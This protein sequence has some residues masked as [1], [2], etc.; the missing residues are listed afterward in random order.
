MVLFDLGDL[1][2]T[3]GD[4]GF[5]FKDGNQHN[6]LL[7]LN[8][9]FRNR[10]G[11][12]FEGAFF[13]GDGLADFEVDRNL[14]CDFFGGFALEWCTSFFGFLGCFLQQGRGQHVEDFLLA[15]WNRV[16]RITDETSDTRCVPD[17]SPSVFG[18]FHADQ[19]VARNT[20]AVDYL[21][22]GVLKLDDF[23]HRNLDFVNVVFDFESLHTSLEVCFDPTFVP[24]VGVDD[25]P[26]TG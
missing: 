12:R 11:Q 13:D 6:E 20:Y 10:C 15:Q 4:R 14:W 18:H 7:R 17:S 3:K 24:R 9:D 26:F 25:I 5:A 21:A 1:M 16:V 22:H 8:F 23:F 2:E 19:D